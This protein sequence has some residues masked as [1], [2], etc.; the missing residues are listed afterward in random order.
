MNKELILQE[1]YRQ[2]KHWQ[3]PET[4]FHELKS[5]SHSR[6]LLSELKSFLPKRQILSI[7]GL[8]RVGKTILLK[9]LIK[10]LIKK[11]PAQNI[12]FLNFDEVL[13]SKTIK[14]ENY[15]NIY[16]EEISGLNK[17]EKIYVFLDEIQYID[18]W[19]HII[20]RY[21]DTDTR[22]KF[23]ISGSSSLFLRKKTT[24]SLVGR[25]FEF[26]LSPLTFVEYLKITDN[27]PDNYLDILIQPGEKVAENKDRNNFFFKYKN[28]MT[29]LFEN[30]VKFGQF[31]E[32]ASESDTSFQKKYLSQAIYNKSIE[33][34]I[35]KIFKVEKQ[36][37]LK[38]LFRVFINEATSLIE[39]KNIAREV[40]LSQETIKKYL[41]YFESSFMVSVLYNFSKSFRRS[42]KTLKKIYLESGNFCSA[43]YDYGNY[44]LNCQY[45]GKLAENYFFNLLKSKFE[46]LAFYQVRQKEFD[47]VTSNDLLNKSEYKYF[48]VKYKNNIKTSDFKFLQNIASKEKFY[49]QVIS[50]DTLVINKDYSILP[51]WMVES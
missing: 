50:K 14:F 37:D 8:R 28:K 25:I 32:I 26:Y 1:I 44:E 18:K 38:F 41:S 4:F 2:N 13:L 49:F 42:K 20:K 51:I 10:Q 48:E 39:I 7:V 31:P 36:E 9:Q 30:Y 33:Y 5:I 21:Y 6:D 19:Q 12:L 47:F 46:Y 15:L 23:V 43:F 34:D 16:L 35:P 45:L 40:E 29:S 27:L 11:V 17:K 3:D 22:I 24:E